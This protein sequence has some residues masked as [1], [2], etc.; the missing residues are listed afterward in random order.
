MTVTPTEAIFNYPGQV[1]LRSQILEPVYLLTDDEAIRIVYSV[2]PAGNQY[3]IL[4]EAK[5]PAVDEIGNHKKKWMVDFYN[6]GL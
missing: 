6:L 4:K 1:Y 2:T 5:L 3:S